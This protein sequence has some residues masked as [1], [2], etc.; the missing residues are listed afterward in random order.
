MTY[1]IEKRT[2]DDYD[3]R[4]IV[5]TQ[6]AVMAMEHTNFLAYPEAVFIEPHDDASNL[7]VVCDNLNKSLDNSTISRDDLTIVLDMVEA[8]TQSNWP[9]VAAAMIERGYT[10]EEIEA[11][12]EKASKI[13][14]ITNPISASDF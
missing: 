12:F 14:H 3:Y 2:W 10:P 9:A 6:G 5:D 4:V 7:D 13:A 8:A 11:A 1:K